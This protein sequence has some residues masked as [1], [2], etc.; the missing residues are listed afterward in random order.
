[1]RAFIGSHL[2]RVALA[3]ANRAT[4]AAAAAATVAAVAAVCDGE[5][6]GGGGKNTGAWEERGAQ[7]KSTATGESRER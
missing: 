4:T 7:E 1:M 6:D 2:S 3:C 5:D